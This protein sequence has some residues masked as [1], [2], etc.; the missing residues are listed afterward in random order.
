MKP[1]N[2]ETNQEQKQRNITQMRNRNT[3]TKKT[4]KETE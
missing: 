4:G 2:K 1:R 3:E